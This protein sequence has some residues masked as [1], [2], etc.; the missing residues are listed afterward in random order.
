ME[1]IAVRVDGGPERGMGH[2]MRCLALT[3]EF[4]DEFDIVFITK[5]EK[6][7]IDTLKNTRYGHV[8]LPEDISYQNEVEKVKKILKDR[9]PDIFIGDIYHIESSHDIDENY[10]KE[11][12]KFVE[13]TVLISPKESL[14]LPYDIVI[15]GNVFAEDL[16]YK[17]LSDDTI[18]LLGPKYALLRNEFKDLPDIDVKEKVTNILVTM[19]GGDLL[20]LTPKAIKAVESLG[21][22]DIHVDVIVGPAAH[23]RVDIENTITEVDTN[24]TLW[25][26]PPKISELMLKADLAISAGGGTLYELAAVGTP[27]IVLLQAD[28]QKRIADSMQEKGTAKVLGF[29]DQIKADEVKNSIRELIEDEKQRKIM[30]ERGKKLFDGLGAVRCADIILKRRGMIP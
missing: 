3:E 2:L 16:E 9:E 20:N 24:V 17:T 8:N 28:N 25:S 1:N 7:V 11:I 26:D 10:L 18:F 4:S 19:G 21:K 14:V 27:A 22:D 29:G 6:S 15:N 23:N 5:K 12:K 13:E 30:S